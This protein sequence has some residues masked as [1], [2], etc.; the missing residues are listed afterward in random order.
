[1]EIALERLFTEE[2]EGG[3]RERE[4]HEELETTWAGEEE[5]EETLLYG[6][7]RFFPGGLWDSPPWLGRWAGGGS[8]VLQ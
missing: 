6:V 7:R 3:E 1:M 4:R 2:Q 5:R 8:P